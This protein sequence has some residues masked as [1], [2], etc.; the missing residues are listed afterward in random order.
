MWS[1]RLVS[2]ACLCLCW[3]LQFPLQGAARNLETTFQGVHVDVVNRYATVNYMF[4]FSNTGTATEL[5]F[6]T[7]LANGMFVHSFRAVLNGH[8]FEGETKEKKEASTEYHEAVSSGHSA[9]LISQDHDASTFTVNC[10]LGQGSGF[11]NVTAQ[12]FLSRRFGFYELSLFLTKIN[13]YSEQIPISISIFDEGG[14][15]DFD[16]PS[17]TDAIIS[18]ADALDIEVEYRDNG[19]S[20]TAN[21]DVQSSDVSSSALNIVLRYTTETMTD[22]NQFY[23][24]AE[25][26]FLHIFSR[27]NAVRQVCDRAKDVD[28]GC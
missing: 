18:L 28:S 19:R 11:V 7:E 17:L 10:N 14:V 9:V 12:Q 4:E 22:N 2:V 25:G 15:S 8:L 23:V 6:E 5:E 1:S 26:R 20:L 21:F 16:T 24:D 3:T 13:S 27:E